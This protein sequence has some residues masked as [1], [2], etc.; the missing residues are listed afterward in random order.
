MKASAGM[1][2]IKT[3]EAST[4]ATVIS[5]ILLYPLDTVRKCI[6]MNGS[7]GNADIYKSSI[8]CFKNIY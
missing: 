3:F 1:R 2:F 6:Q 7:T 4:L 8:D 5:V